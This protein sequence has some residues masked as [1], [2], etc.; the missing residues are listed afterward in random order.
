M[1]MNQGSPTLT[2]PMFRVGG[3]GKLMM[4]ITTTTTTTGTNTTNN[5]KGKKE[6]KFSALAALKFI[7][8]IHL[9]IYYGQIISSMIRE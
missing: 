7:I 8:F 9:H 5:N 3:G 2:S 6:E 1:V 4:T